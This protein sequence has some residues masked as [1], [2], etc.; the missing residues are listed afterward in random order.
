MADRPDGYGFTA[1]VRG[2][3]SSKYDSGREREALQWIEA[4]LG[5]RVFGGVQG[6]DAVHQ[7]LKDGVILCKLIN[8]IKPGSVKKINDSKMAFKMME[9]IGNF[10]D[11]CMA[12]GIQKLDTFQTVDLYEN[13]NMTQVIDG[14]HALGRKAPSV[15]YRGPG[16]GPK[17][18]TANK[19]E[20]TEQ[21]RRAGDGIIGLQAGYNKG[22]SQAGQNFGKTR[23]IID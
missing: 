21:Q 18:A 20:F 4:V 3:L 7:K 10:L 11:A 14:I 9:N 6:S 8:K 12:I 15:G 19:R 5:E 2:K 1:E 23:A 13:Q 17:E 16:L 22:A